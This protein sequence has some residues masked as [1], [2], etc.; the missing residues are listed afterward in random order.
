MV[1]FGTFTNTTKWD[2]LIYAI[3]TAI[4][5]AFATAWQRVLQNYALIHFQEEASTPLKSSL[6]IAGLVTVALALALRILF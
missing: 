4:I 1:L 6:L 2:V 3:M 5:F